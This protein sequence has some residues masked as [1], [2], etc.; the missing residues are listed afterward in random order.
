VLL[1]LGTGIGGGIILNGKLVTG[2]RGAGAELGHI[3]V[4]TAG[5]LCG[6]GT[7][8]CL[9]AYASMRGIQKSY[10]GRLEV[11]EIFEKRDARARKAIA[12]A[13]K[14]L[15]V[16]IASIV[17]ALEPE[18]VILAGGISQAGPAYLKRIREEARQRR[19]P[20]R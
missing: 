20:V 10:G 15:G 5:R 6:C 8:G 16:A 17:N 9:E 14:S 4:E 12:L 7:R 19:F 18:R 2:S 11:R 1:T 13:A 3:K